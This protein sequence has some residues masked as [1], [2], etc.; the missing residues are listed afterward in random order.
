MPEFNIVI[1]TMKE[2]HRV[3]YWVVITRNDRDKDCMPWDDRDTR[4][5]PFMSEE[6]EHACIEAYSWARF[7][8]CEVD[9]SAVKDLPNYPTEILEL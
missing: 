9:N 3:T 7:L 2:S 4:R 5:T 6:L 1:S 8:Q